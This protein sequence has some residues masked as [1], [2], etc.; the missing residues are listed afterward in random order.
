VTEGSSTRIAEIATPTADTFTTADSGGTLIDETEYSYRVS[1]L[2]ADGESLAFEAVQETTLATG[3][4]DENT[5]TV[6]WLEVTGATSYN[7]YGRTE[8][9]ESLLA[10][11]AAPTVEW[12]DDGSETPSGVEPVAENTTNAGDIEYRVVY[13][14]SGMTKLDALKALDAIRLKIEIAIVPVVHTFYGVG[15]G[16]GMPLD[17]TVDTSTTSAVCELQV[18]WGDAD[19]NRLRVLNALKALAAYITR[20]TWAPA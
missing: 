17:V 1:A 2:D 5:I 18:D 20:D 4:G 9:S 6:K 8:G 11:V 10:N 19:V 15:L 16:G 13:T 7:V 3:A 12:E 14:T